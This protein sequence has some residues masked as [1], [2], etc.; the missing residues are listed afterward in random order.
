M[1]IKRDSPAM[2]AV[3]K[4]AKVPAIIARTAKAAKSDLRVGAMALKPPICTPM[5]PMLAKPHR[6]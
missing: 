6:A 5:D 2:Q 1:A 3:I 4:Q